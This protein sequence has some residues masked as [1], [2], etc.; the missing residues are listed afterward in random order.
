MSMQKQPKVNIPQYSPEQV[1]LV[2]CLLYGTV[3]LSNG[4]LL[5]LADFCNLRPE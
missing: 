1:R 3:S 2:S 5:C 4:T